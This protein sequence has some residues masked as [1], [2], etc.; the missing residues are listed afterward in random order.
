M[1]ARRF[2]PL[3]RRCSICSWV[4]C[5][6]G[7]SSRAGT[8]HASSE[9]DIGLNVRPKRGLIDL[10]GAAETAHDGGTIRLSRLTLVHDDERGFERKRS[11]RS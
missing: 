11:S 8:C 6:E 9:A 3:T 4:S 5:P 7:L 1:L 10:E 2:V